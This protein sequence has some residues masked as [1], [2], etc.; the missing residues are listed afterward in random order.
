M[1][2]FSS[3]AAGLLVAGSLFTPAMAKPSACWVIPAGGK[4]VNGQACNVH[5]RTN[6]N[7]HRVHDVTLTHEGDSA[8]F[9]VILWK[10]EAGNPEHAEVILNGDR[11]TPSWHRD[12][13]G[14]IRLVFRS[15]NQIA[16][17]L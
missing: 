6:N 12:A 8:T 9:T 5:T 10:N 15:G 3:V 4:L 13:D 11:W 14:D 2:L 17:R 7:G 16:F 1:K